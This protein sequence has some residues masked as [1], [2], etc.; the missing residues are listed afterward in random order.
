[1]FE[2]KNPL[3]EGGTELD[4]DKIKELYEVFSLIDEKYL[5]D[6]KWIAGESLS[7]ADF[8]Y[9]STVAGLIVSQIEVVSIL[10]SSLFSSQQ[11]TGASI[12]RFT[13][14]QKWYRNCQST[15][16][17]FSE[18]TEKGAKMFGDWV[19]AAATKGF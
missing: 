17:D 7:V 16:I 18:I 5:V 15:F 1:L 2:F 3:F 8:A 9:A 6:G 10:F 12:E 4:Q 14:L 13:Q 11:A 19:K